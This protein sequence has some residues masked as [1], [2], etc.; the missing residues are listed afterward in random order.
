MRS[1]KNHNITQYVAL[2]NKGIGAVV[3]TFD[4]LTKKDK[5][6]MVNYLVIPNNFVLSLSSRA[7]V[8][9]LIFFH[10]YARAKRGVHPSKQR[11]FRKFPLFF[12]VSFPELYKRQNKN[13][14]SSDFITKDNCNSLIIV[15]FLSLI[16]RAGSGKTLSA[17]RGGEGRRLGGIDNKVIRMYIIKGEQRSHIIESR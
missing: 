13:V 3:R 17:C 1:I 12:F 7:G 4:S 5:K 15:C 10:A 9:T 16:S 14:L 11:T 8:T 6:K 2:Y